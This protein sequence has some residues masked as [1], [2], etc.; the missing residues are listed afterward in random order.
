MGIF[1]QLITSC[2]VFYVLYA[3]LRITC[4]S[5]IVIFLTRRFEIKLIFIIIYLI[6]LICMTSKMRSQCASENSNLYIFKADWC[7]WSKFTDLNLLIVRSKYKMCANLTFVQ[8]WNLYRNVN[9]LNFGKWE[10]RISY[11]FFLFIAIIILDW[12]II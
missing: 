7:F 5:H 8:S 1:T 10:L 11:I 2:S 6:Q 12:N 3:T 9:K 4:F